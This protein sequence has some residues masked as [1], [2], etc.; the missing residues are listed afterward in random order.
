MLKEELFCSSDGRPFQRI[1]GR[2]K[3]LERKEDFLTRGTGYV[4]FLKI[5]G[6]HRHLVSCFHSTI[7]LLADKAAK[8]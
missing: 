7:L 4:S 2:G 5:F 3:K 8:S 6:C 1:I